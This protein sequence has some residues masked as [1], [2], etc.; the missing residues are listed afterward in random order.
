MSGW[1]GAG[2]GRYG[3]VGVELELRGKKLLSWA[4]PATE[5]FL[6]PSRPPIYRFREGASPVS[7]K[8]LKTGHIIVTL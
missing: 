3:Y 1:G 5:L 8:S 4:Q 7:A 6:V 2:W